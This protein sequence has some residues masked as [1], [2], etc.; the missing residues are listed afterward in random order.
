MVWP[1]KPVKEQKDNPVGRLIF[2]RQ[3]QPAWTDRE[4][5]PLAREGYQQNAVVFTCVSRIARAASSVKLQLCR[6]SDG[7]VE[8]IADHPILDLLSNPNPTQSGHEFIEALI[9]FRLL[10]GNSYILRSALTEGLLN[11]EPHE[12]WLMRPDMVKVIEGASGL[13]SAYRFESSGGML[14]FPVDQLSGSSDV[15]HMRSFN[16]LSNYYGQSE[17]EAASHS[18]DIFNSSQ[19]WNYG[20]LKNGARPSGALRV[21]SK[22]GSQDELT[23]E[24]YSRQKNEIDEMFSGA[25]NSGK[26]LLLEGG[27]EWQDMMLS[28]RDM[29]FKDNQI[30]AAK[31]I[32]V[33]YGVPPE[34]LSLGQTIYNNYSEAKVAFWQDTILPHVSMM[35]SSLN[36]WLVP[37]YG[38]DSLFLKFDEDSITAL[39]TKREQKFNRIKDSDFMTVNEKRRALGMDDIDGGDVLFIDQGKIPLSLASDGLDVTE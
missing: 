39:E 33:S 10:A 35:L 17:M 31:F 8:I 36:N 26:P 18:V 24:Q 19:T 27:L 37:Q 11:T 12:L 9:A 28:P 38:D 7:G 6:N 1:F 32:A 20:L 13:P 2:T 5:V 3:G 4:Y 21:V 29:D 16:P 22:D 14:D 23:D 15:M 34:L 30:Q 25:E